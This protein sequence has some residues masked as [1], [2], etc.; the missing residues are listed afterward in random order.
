MKYQTSLE[1]F[2]LRAEGAVST[3]V[4]TPHPPNYSPYLK[5]VSIRNLGTPH[6][7]VTRDPLNMEMKFLPV[8]IFIY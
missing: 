8:F 7:V 3:A 6:S 4:T 5:T 1:K 2:Y